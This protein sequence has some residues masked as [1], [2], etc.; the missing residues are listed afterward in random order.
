MKSHENTCRL[1]AFDITE[2]MD[3]L[4]Q[5]IFLG[6]MGAGDGGGAMGCSSAGVEGAL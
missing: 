5:N 1:V 2:E 3:R 4:I 6:Y